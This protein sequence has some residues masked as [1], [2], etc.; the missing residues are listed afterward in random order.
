MNQAASDH[1]QRSR[2]N[3]YKRRAD[4]GVSHSTDRELTYP[5]AVEFE[6]GKVRELN[7]LQK[8][9]WV[10]DGIR[11]FLDKQYKPSERSFTEVADRKD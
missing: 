7:F 3:S 9:Q 6:A 4:N 1:A 5:V 11:K 10:S 2:T 8:G